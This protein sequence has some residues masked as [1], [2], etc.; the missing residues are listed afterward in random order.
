MAN[1]LIAKKKIPKKLLKYFKLK[2]QNRFILRNVIIWEKP[3]AMPSSVKDRFSVNYEPVFFFSKSKKYWFETQYEK[4]SEVYLNENRPAG[5][6]R[7]RLYPN[8]KYVKAGMVKLEHKAGHKDWQNGMNKRGKD[9]V[10]KLHPELGRNKRC[11]W[12]IPNE[13]HYVEIDGKFYK[14]SEDCPIHSPYLCREMSQKE[15][16]DGQPNQKSNYISDISKSPVQ[17]QVS[18]SSSIL[19]HDDENHQT[20]PANGREQ[21]A[22]NISENK[23]SELP[24]D[25]GVS[26]SHLG[27][28][29]KFE[30]PVCN[31]GSDCHNDS[32]IATLHNKENHKNTSEK[33]L[34][35][36]ASDRTSY[37]KFDKKQSDQVLDLDS[38]Y[39]NDSKAKCSCQ[40][41]AK[42][43]FATNN[44]SVWKISTKGFSE[45]H[46]ATFPEKLIEPMI[47]AGCPQWVCSR[48]GKARARIT[49][50]E[51][52][53]VHKSPK[54]T[55]RQEINI[56]TIGWTDCGCKDYFCFN[57]K[58]FLTNDTNTIGDIIHC[59]V[60]KNA[61]Q[62]QKLQNTLGKK[63]ISTNES[64]G[65]IL[66]RNSKL[67]KKELFEL[68]KR[69]LREKE[70]TN[71][72]KE[73]WSS[74]ASKTRDSSY[75]SKR[76]TLSKLERRN[77]QQQWLQNN[78]SQSQ[79]N[80]RTSLDNGTI[81]GE[82]INNFGGS[83]PQK[84][85]QNRQQNRE[86]RD[87]LENEPQWSDCLSLLSKIFQT[88]IK[89]PFCG[90]HKIDIVPSGFEPGIVLDPFMGA[91][92]TAV[93][94][95]K[96]GRNYLGI[97]LNQSYIDI[98]KKRLAQGILI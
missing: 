98:V 83:S 21:I 5:V 80:S 92:T 65:K 16:Y 2:T 73:M 82:E 6:L 8:S 19:C 62:K 89:C 74:M 14:V 1:V 87:C 81:F 32:R 59:E 43:D 51:Y 11:V 33:V 17:E 72:F 28:E 23:T 31:S 96:L 29:H 78:N 13:N 46:F 85:H 64:T 25:K 27:I 42:A 53:N 79:S 94:A 55:D 95:K 44:G 57:C 86:F 49:K 15:S 88:E 68:W 39:L 36:N 7:Q 71:L 63:Q 12:K 91:G 18:E 30:N 41:V 9:A 10:I 20:K 50:K 52:N 40:E 67:Q 61:T 26:Q 93:V 38:P 69:I 58:K 45:A 70:A 56:Q 60:N 84:Q 66:E 35:D 4:F 34:D 97:E 54:E 75:I 47:L 77:N 76:E 24:L 37:H 22:Q 90:S 48:C 3:N